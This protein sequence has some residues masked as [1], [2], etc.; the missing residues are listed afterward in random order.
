[1]QLH[2][3]VFQII[4]DKVRVLTYQVHYIVNCVIVMG[5]FVGVLTCMFFFF[6]YNDESMS[7]ISLSEQSSGRALALPLV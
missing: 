6:D 1:M 4:S 3:R 5:T 7:V 2:N